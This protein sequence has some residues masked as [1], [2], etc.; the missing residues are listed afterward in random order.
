MPDVTID[1][2]RVW[3]CDNPACE[4]PFCI[5]YRNGD[6]NTNTNATPRQEAPPLPD[7]YP[8]PETTPTVMPFTRTVGHECEYASGSDL[9]SWL[10]ARGHTADD[11][12]HG[13]QCR[14]STANRFAIHSTQDGTAPGGEYLIGGSYGVVFGSEPY[15]KAVRILAEGVAAVRNEISEG[16]GMHTHVGTSDLNQGDK[17]TLLRNYLVYQDQI[18]LLAAGSF[19]EVRNNGC[20]TARLEPSSFER[21]CATGR[22]D[23]YRVDPDALAPVVYLPSRPTLNFQGRNP[24]VEFRVW[25][26]AR[27]A[28]RMV[29]AGAVSAAMVEAAKQRR[30]ANFD[31]PG[32]LTDFL[33]GLLT[34]DVVVLI[35]RQ[36]KFQ[37]KIRGV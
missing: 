5:R 32:D 37:S 18:L 14:C 15:I 17:V 33:R 28:W 7:F 24:T 19:R 31:S 22:S 10:F 3:V 4:N 20:T 11:R 30:Y 23:F 26:S 12:L 8:P 2:R 21:A 16:V 36:R 25:N 6:T 9:A 13:Y 35:D 29:L 27:S 1:G 34:P